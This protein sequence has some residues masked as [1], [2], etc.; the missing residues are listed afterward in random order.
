VSGRTNAWRLSAPNLGASTIV[1]RTM[2]MKKI[3]MKSMEQTLLAY[4]ARAGM[5]A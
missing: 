4:P 3:V 5:R 2:A 1:P